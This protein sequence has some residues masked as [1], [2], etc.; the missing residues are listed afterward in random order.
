MAKGFL[1]G[2]LTGVAVSAVGLGA[3]SELLPRPGSMAPHR[4]GAPQNAATDKPA[5]QETAAEVPGA[6]AAP[7]AA[8][9]AAAQAPVQAGGSA[10]ESAT[11][12]AT[13]A[14]DVRPEASTGTGA[15]VPAPAP[16]SAPTAE[17]PAAVAPQVSASNTGSQTAPLAG[18]APAAPP[19][20]PPAA[21]PSTDIAAAPVQGAPSSNPPSTP[22]QP[23]FGAPIAIPPGDRVPESGR[24]V[25]PP[26]ISDG[27]RAPAPP[28]APQPETQTPAAQAP[29][30]ETPVTETPPAAT[31][32]P[33][34][35]AGPVPKFLVPP[36]RVAIDSTAPAAPQSDP[37]TGTAN[38][39]PPEGPDSAET[40][41]D[42]PR[43]VARPAAPA[44]AEAPASAMETPPPAPRPRV[45]PLG[46]GG[47]D[48]AGNG[49]LAEG[50]GAPRVKAPPATAPLPRIAGG[51]P[52]IAGAPQPGFGQ[53]VNGVVVGRLPTIGAAP[54]ASS[55]DPE[56]AQ[57]ADEG[58]GAAPS[59]AL[60]GQHMIPA[61][62]AAP[63]DAASR[64]PIRRYASPF[65]NPQRKPLL[66]IILIDDGGAVD[67]ADLA[68]LPL[69]LT[70][71]IDPTRPG[72]A[73]DAQIYRKAGR[74]VLILANS[75][76][77]GASEGEIATLFE[78]YRSILP[79]AVGVIDA[80]DG[81]FESN[82]PLSEAVVDELA[83]Q[84]LGLVTYA[85]GLDAA[86][87]IAQS[88]DLPA[89]KIYRRLDANKENSFIIGRY[90]D[91]AAFQAAQDGRVIVVGHTRPDTIS[92]LEKWA[93]TARA[94]SLAFGP[95]T[96]ALSP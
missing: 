27:A 36:P 61:P 86:N 88:R 67:R 91:R 5:G 62:G 4:V 46:D 58:R 14:P 80:A 40:L 51:L 47:G 74:E 56:T 55:G 12:A 1:I 71:A 87:K 93:G 32:A 83:G 85:R 7:D 77:A 6:P 2:A 54:G 89:G 84:G 76:P 11:A 70:F 9:D 24:P 20:T 81:G 75:I 33:P 95:V 39:T 17:A 23:G 25:L 18:T 35:A 82:R 48:G 13:A 63:L 73:E 53:T 10:T 60:P 64:Q 45:V 38:R 22:P 92:G 66:S 96:A 21:A 37:G 29:S 26:M 28:Q 30:A 15:D 59:A 42:T 94:R 44:A 43:A 19:V 16:D 41:P 57:P 49:G 50:S 72:A 65:E 90:L 31:P 3:I 34:A 69:D 79:E 8:P 78:S 52:R 68:A